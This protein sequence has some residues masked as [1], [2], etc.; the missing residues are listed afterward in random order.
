MSAVEDGD[1]PEPTDEVVEQHNARNGVR[2][3]VVVRENPLNG[4][5]KKLLKVYGTR[6]DRYSGLDGGETV[7]KRKVKIAQF[8]ETNGYD[9]LQGLAE[10]YGYEL[11]PK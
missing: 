8:A 1:D 6:S 3:D 2:T 11:R 10:A 5:T 7:R 4:E 9:I